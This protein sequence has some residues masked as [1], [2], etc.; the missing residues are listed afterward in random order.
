MA[1]IQALEAVTIVSKSGDEGKLFGSIGT[2]DI[3]NALTAAGVEVQKSEVALPLGAIRQAGDHEVEVQ[4][5][6]DVKGTFTLSIVP[7]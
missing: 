6:T 1:K 7:E 4:V 2:R 5:H 3:A